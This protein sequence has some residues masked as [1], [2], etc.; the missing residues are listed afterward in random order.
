MAYAVFDVE[1]RV[2]KALLNRVYHQGEGLADDDAYERHRAEL[3][4]R[5]SDFFP[6]TLHIPISVAVGMVGDDHILR[7]VES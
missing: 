7:S 2:D 4:R 3:N 6:I 5:G 1:T